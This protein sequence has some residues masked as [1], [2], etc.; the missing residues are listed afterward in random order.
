M[1]FNF[2]WGQNHIVL[3]T[4]LLLTKFKGYTVK[5]IHYD[6]LSG[7]VI[8]FDSWSIKIQIIQT[9]S[10]RERMLP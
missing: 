8:I 1:E 3:D 4:I 6:N 10:Q 5:L 7:L 9:K 2:S